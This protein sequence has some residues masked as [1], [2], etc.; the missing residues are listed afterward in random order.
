MICVRNR[1][2]VAATQYAQNANVMMS[3]ADNMIAAIDEL[4]GRTDE[5]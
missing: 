3:I 2:I 1:C 5:P 4:P